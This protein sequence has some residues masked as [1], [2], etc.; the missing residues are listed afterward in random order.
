VQITVVYH[1][2][3]FVPFVGKYLESPV[4]SGSRA[5]SATTRMQIEPCS[6]TQGG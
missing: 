5:V 2:P 3:V 6:I 1:A 4:G